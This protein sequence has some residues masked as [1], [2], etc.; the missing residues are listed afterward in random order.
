M[1][2]E[3]KEF[4]GTTKPSV[5]ATSSFVLGFVACY[6][7]LTAHISALVISLFCVVLISYAL[8]LDYKQGFNVRWR[9][10]NFIFHISYLLALLFAV[11][12]ILYVFF[13]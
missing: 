9:L 5:I 11:G 7:A 12:F 2:I 3:T 1:K 13:T 10:S 4:I 6:F 8:M